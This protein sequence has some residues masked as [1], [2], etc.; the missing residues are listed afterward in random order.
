MDDFIK[1]IPLLYFLLSTSFLQAGEL[2]Q[3]DQEITLSLQGMGLSLVNNTVQKEIAYMSIISSGVV[4][5]T[6]KKKRYKA[7]KMKQSTALEAA[8]QKY[9]QEILTGGKA[10]PI[11]KIGKM[12]VS[13]VSLPPTNGVAGR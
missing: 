3:S 13:K 4:W 2:E 10:N 9:Q 5:E 6:K 11:V 8:Y 1:K 7:L 12:E